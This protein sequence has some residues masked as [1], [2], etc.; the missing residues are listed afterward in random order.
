MELWTRGRVREFLEREG[1]DAA[2]VGTYCPPGREPG[3]EWQWLPDSAT[4]SPTGIFILTLA[5]TQVALAPPFKPRPPFEPWQ[6]CLERVLAQERLV[7]ILLL[8]L[9]H[10]AVGVAGNEGVVAARS[11][12]RYVHGRH[13]AG[14]QS[15]RRWER[16]REQWIEKLFDEVCDRWRSVCGPYGDRMDALAIGGDRIVLGRFFKH[17]SEVGALHDR[18]EVR[19]LPVD[20]PGSDAMKAAAEAAWSS[21]V[22]RKSSAAEDPL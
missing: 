5:G 20:R 12:A 14:G 4:R 6:D 1:R 19:R 11:G 10:Y 17:C 18:V 9:G 22:L 15:Q 8:R 3:A 2:T 7:G 13:R 21:V 16:N